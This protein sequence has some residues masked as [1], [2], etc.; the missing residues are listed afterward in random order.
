MSEQ[1]VTEVHVAIVGAG[2]AALTAHRSVLKANRTA[3]MID[4]GPYGTTCARTGC[5]PSKLLIAAANAAH[6]ARH[7][8]MFGVHAEV[9]VDG[10]QVMRRV[11]R[12]RDRF[13]DHVKASIQEAIERGDV[14]Q[15]CATITSSNELEIALE[16]GST[17]RVR[18]ERLILAVGSR[19]MTPPPFRHLDER[20]MLTNESV[21]ELN[22]L[23]ES[24]LV[25]GLGVI[26]LELGQAMHRLGV[27]VTL[28]GQDGQVGMLH[29]QE[30][31]DHARSVLKKELDMHPEYQLHRIEMSP[32]REGV[33]MAFTDSDGD[34][35]EEHFEKILMAAGRRTNLDRV[36]LEALDIKP[37]DQGQY[38][39]N[40]GTLQLRDRPIFV[41]GDANT[42]HP[43][44]H[45]AADDGRLAAENAVRYPEVLAPRRREPLAIMF[46]EPQIAIIGH[47]DRSFHGLEIASGQIDFSDQ[48]RARVM[49]ENE[50]IFKIYAEYESGY[51]LGGEFFGPRAEHM[52]H[53]LA[54]AVQSG[55]TVDQALGMPFYHP[56]FEE[57][58]RTALRHLSSEIKHHARISCRIAE[59]GVGS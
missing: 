36:G 47:R 42:L 48:G 28:V 17:S 56:V 30:L 46:T 31:I 24:L 9:H 5:M 39:I 45:E 22:D 35:R 7:A 14:I 54:W 43:L 27:R 40:Q 58:L 37:D 50:G 16:D 12:E 49:G 2:S 55:M 32:E 8:S 29:D 20:V 52:A 6:Q 34:E 3:V 4:P 41:A 10:E 11:Q 33:T 19:P 59:L 18:F 15:G 44:L 13:V 53:L 25:V 23:P 21:F 1:S 38:G 51:L 26:G 57:G